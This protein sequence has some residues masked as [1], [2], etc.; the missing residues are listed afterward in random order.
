M[1]GEV[2]IVIGVDRDL[3]KRY[4]IVLKQISN[5]IKLQKDLNIDIIKNSNSE[6]NSTKLLLDILNN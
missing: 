4:A 2:N 5:D 1:F 3:S 6:E